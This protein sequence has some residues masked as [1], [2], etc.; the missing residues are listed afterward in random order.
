MQISKLIVCGTLSL[1]LGF[2]ATANDKFKRKIDIGQKSEL[3]LV[4]CNIVVPQKT[5]K[6]AAFA[7]KE[8]QNYLS[9]SFGT[10][11]PIV[12]S[13]ASKKVSII[14]GN[15]TTARKY[16]INIATLPRDGFIIKTIGKNIIIVGKDDPKVDPVR[17]LKNR[18]MWKHYY[19]RATLFGVYDFLERFVGVRFYFPGEIGTVIP[20]HKTL[21][22]PAINITDAPDYV[23]RTYTV[24]EQWMKRRI[25]PKDATR[26]R[27][28]NTYRLR[29]S[30]S[31]IPNCHGLN[32]RGYLKRYG[33]THPEYFAMMG[34]GKRALSGEP[35]PQLCYNSGI[36]DEIYK[37]AK[38]FLEGNSAASRG[39]IT[40]WGAVWSQA[41]ATKGYYNIMPQDG[42][43]L[44]QCAKCKPLF[45]KGKKAASDAIWDFFCGIAERV[46]KNKIPGYITTMAYPPY[47]RVPD[48]K[49]PDN[50]I[51][52]LAVRGPWQ[53][54]S[55]KMQN[56]EDDRVKRWG[57]KV[58]GKLE[59][60]TYANKFS[61]L[62]IIGV[63]SFTPRCIA[64]YYAKQKDYILGAYMES[65]SESFYYHYLNYYVFSK[66][67]WN[68]STDI[69]KLLTE[70]YKSMYGPAAK[71]MQDI[72][73]SFEKKWTGK[74]FGV[75]YNSPMG[76]KT[77]PASDY[78]IWTQIYS[79]AALKKLDNDFKQAEKI[80][81]KDALI[82]KRIKFMR[83]KFLEPLQK[84]SKKYFSLKNK[85]SGMTFEVT[86]KT[87]ENKIVIDGIL[88]ESAWA[89][90]GKVTFVPLGKAKGKRV[91]TTLYALK[92]KDKLYLAFNCSEPQMAKVIAG[93]RKKDDSSIWKDNSVEIF[94]NP[95]GDKKH[96]YHFT[97]NSEGALSDAAS[98]KKG[99]SQEE[100]LKWD[101]GAE[102][103]VAKNKT[104][105]TLEIAIPLKSLGNE[106][107]DQFPANFCRSRVLSDVKDYVIYYSWSPFLKKGFHDLE[108]FGSIILNSKGTM[109]NLLTNSSFEND[110]FSGRYLGKWY[111]L[112]AKLANQSYSIDSNVS[113]A[114]AR[115]L[116][117][118]SSGPGKAV[119]SQAVVGLKPNTEYMLVYYVKLDN[120]KPN[121]R[122]P[123][124]CANIWDGKNHWL[125]KK[126][127]S[128]TMPWTKQVYK[129][130]TS[131]QKPGKKFQGIFRL[132]L[133]HV[134]GTAWFDNI[135][136]YELK[137]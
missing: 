106:I 17:A 68:T 47:E 69:D 89:K 41:S 65:E 128:G 104:S 111:G 105:W 91:A 4:G 13:P 55:A 72:F 59:L 87:A 96:Y 135:K 99:S 51:V 19:E 92:G 94:L 71:I 75:P 38:A 95:S 127:F 9:K 58:G 114:G 37:D 118:S 137:K 70:H 116:K 28:F 130:K 122:Y 48:R 131:A 112:N 84:A 29:T 117:L 33:K 119:L 103:K 36:T 54:H 124:V 1:L 76:P 31:Y 109:K 26:M 12:K 24:N 97:I 134:T 27:R 30:T 129:F 110:K 44:C 86:P 40:K 77:A 64:S 121:G 10:Q 50:M 74:I 108:S 7:A 23:A 46:K 73:E 3:S 98:L 53:E 93:K 100:N 115:S 123:G 45:A 63:P 34:N 133:S 78:Q 56:L 32:A 132:F 113:V 101:S 80:T 83:Q 61:K 107:K 8:L 126:W 49:V 5:S 14:V 67:C 35:T 52:K 81:Q 57:E 42:M 39:V 82:L 85:I 11:V 15:S 22:V 90:C 79:P 6:V 16:G 62:D 66:T 43:I 21:A 125:P 102:Y 60:W 25:L 18:S 136:L 88:N 20:K 120:V 2:S